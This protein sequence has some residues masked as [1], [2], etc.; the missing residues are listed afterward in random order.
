[1]KEEQIITISADRNSDS[2]QLKVH[3]VEQLDGPN[4]RKLG[5]QNRTVKITVTLLLQNF[6]AT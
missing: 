6:C 4:D 5:S 3:Q 1:M 2:A